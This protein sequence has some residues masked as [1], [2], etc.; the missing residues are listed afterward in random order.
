[1]KQQHGFTLIEIVS[2]VVI[3][4]ILSAVAVPKYFELQEESEKKA[5][6]A[7]VAE[8]QSRL[9]L[10][11]SQSLLQG[12]NCA[13]ALDDINTLIVLS[14]NAD[15]KFDELW[16]G[17]SN[18]PGGMLVASTPIYGGRDAS[19]LM[20]LGVSLFLP[21]C[22]ENESSLISGMIQDALAYIKRNDGNFPSTAS[23]SLINGATLSLLQVKDVP[24]KIILRADI[25]NQ[26]QAHPAL[27]VELQKHN[28]GHI[29]IITA[30]VW[31]D[32]KTKYRLTG[33][34]DEVQWA[35]SL[36]HM[37]KYLGTDIFNQ[38]FTTETNKNGNKILTLQSAYTK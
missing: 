4:G 5:A 30:D 31:L 38:Y 18:S 20:E 29:S 26:S 13:A 14:D 21:T 16:L 1:M 27:S 22:D 9:E 35:D 6:Q 10:Q 34:T 7:S 12:K 28:S 37:Q 32:N 23:I 17:T 11:F 36:N 3:L 15:N 33:N 8:A 24:S 2:V 19:N 25:P